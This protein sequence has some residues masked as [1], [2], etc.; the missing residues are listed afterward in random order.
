V[1]IG[2]LTLELESFVP[3]ERVGTKMRDPVVLDEG[4]LAL[5]VDQS[6]GVDTETLHVSERSGDSSVGKD[7]RL[8]GGRLGVKRHEVPGVV[9]GS[10]SLRDLVVRLRLY[11]VDK[12]D[13][14]DGIC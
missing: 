13:E 12:V 2:V 5:G 10:L 14:L 7:P 6:E 8:H 9:V 11:S 3:N 4:A 1:E